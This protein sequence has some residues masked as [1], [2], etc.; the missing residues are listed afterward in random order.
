[1]D[2]PKYS[3]KEKKGKK[4][5]RKKSHKNYIYIYIKFAFKQ[6]GSFFGKVILGY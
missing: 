1:M 5:Q 2:F 3:I 6:I 4:K